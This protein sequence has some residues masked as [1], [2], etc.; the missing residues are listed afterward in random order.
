MG[1]DV[2]TKDGVSIMVTFTKNGVSHHA[3]HFVEI[4]D[5]Y[6]RNKAAHRCLE[7]ALEKFPRPAETGRRD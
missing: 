2:K 4:P 5:H 3:L 7:F 1:R 6:D